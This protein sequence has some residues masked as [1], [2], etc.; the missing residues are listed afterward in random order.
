[1]NRNEFISELKK[2]W[3]VL[4]SDDTEKILE[5]Y[6]E[7]ID[8]RTDDGMTEEEAVKYVGTPDDIASQI[9]SD[10]SVSKIVKAKVKKSKPKS[11]VVKTL[12]IIGS[13]LWVSLLIALVSVIIT[14]YV[15]IYTLVIVYYVCAAAFAASALFGICTAV[16]SGLFNLKAMF[17]VGTGLVCAGLSI[18]MSCFSKNVISFAVWLTKKIPAAIKLCFTK[19]GD[20]E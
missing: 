20:N 13:P 14:L 2:K 15:V 4:P 12:L 7:M 16:I 8:D 18:L 17:F 1:M 3:S 6:G 5:Y 19:R 10:T 11:A 9:I